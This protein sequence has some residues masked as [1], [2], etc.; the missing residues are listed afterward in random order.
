MCVGLS[1][2]VKAPGPHSWPSSSANAAAPNA[3][4]DDVG[5]T[6]KVSTNAAP[7][8]ERIN[9]DSFTITIMCKHISRN[10]E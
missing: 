8:L 5:P 9:D 10:V 6:N 2:A 3:D 7:A 1:S 4:G